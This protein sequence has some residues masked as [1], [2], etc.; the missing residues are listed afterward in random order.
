MM[1]RFISAMKRFTLIAC[2]CLGLI[3][4]P[5]VAKANF[6]FTLPSAYI[7][8]TCAFGTCVQF[9]QSQLL[10]QI[11]QAYA[12]IQNFKNIQNMAGMQGAAQQVVGIVN[13]AQTT[14]PLQAGNVAAQQI[15]NTESSTTS[16]IAAIDAQAQTASGSQQQA[17]VQSLYASTTASEV[18]K[19]NALLAEQTIQ[20][21][22]QDTDAVNTILTESSGDYGPGSVL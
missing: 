17:Q 14:Q 6:N 10:L 21:Q 11:Q 4:L 20:K 2:V 9:T 5:K 13:A 16:R 15:L 3:V 18:N 12:T 8:D 19:T 22:A 1:K 7:P